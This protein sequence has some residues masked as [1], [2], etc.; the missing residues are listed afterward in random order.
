[1]GYQNFASPSRREILPRREDTGM[2]KFSITIEFTAEAVFL[3]ILALL[4][5][6]G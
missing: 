1:M 4:R 5:I 3:A 2:L 6:C